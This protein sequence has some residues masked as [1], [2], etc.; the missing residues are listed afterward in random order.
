MYTRTENGAKAFASTGDPLVNLFFTIGASR[1]NLPGVMGDFQKAKNFD[2]LKAAAIV[3]WARCIRGREDG[4]LSGAGE[5]TVPRNLLNTYFTN[6]GAYSEQILCLLPVIGRYDDLEAAYGTPYQK[7]AA[8]IWARAI[9]DGNVLAAKWAD[10]SN[11][12]LQREL[13]VNEAALRK[14]LSSM[15]KNHIVEHKICS[16]NFDAIDYG[17]L[18]SLAGLRY[19]KVFHKWDGERYREF[20]DSKT[21]KVNASVALPHEVYMKWRMDRDEP[22]ASKY[23]AA[24]PKMEINGNILPMLDVSGSMM[25]AVAPGSQTQCIDVCIALGVYLAENNTGYYK[26]RALTFSESPT[27]VT[28]PQSYS[29]S[30][31]FQFVNAMNWGMNTNFERAY[32]T[33]LNEAIANK[34]PD[35]QMPT[36]LLVMSD[37]QFDSCGGRNLHLNNIRA[38]YKAAGY[39]CPKLVFWNL[40]TSNGF[41][42]MDETPDVALVSGFSPDVLKAVLACKN[43]TPVDVMEEA[44][45]PFVELLAA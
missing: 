12:P 24:I 42:A 21:T 34:V 18:P 9:Q 14:M 29:L 45:A 19:S 38:K 28:I 23:W 11:T 35:E 5:R 27:L 3:L 13:K 22:V 39:T 41:P 16:K 43:V 10:R 25:S 20:I 40:R 6:R 31:K 33:L 32:T 4:K 2:E 37:M 8:E 1:S 15:R 36:V 44:I 30:K 17:K 7:L 26:N